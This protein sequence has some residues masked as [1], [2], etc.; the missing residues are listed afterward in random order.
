MEKEAPNWVGA[1]GRGEHRTV[2]SH[3]AWCYLCSEWCWSYKEGCCQ[4]CDDE[5]VPPRW[6]GENVGSVVADIRRQVEA[7]EDV[8]GRPTEAGDCL[9][10]AS[11]VLNLLDTGGSD[12]A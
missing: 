5:H 11:A 1:G 2:G 3:R 6:R 4:C 8:M 12:G 10:W 9:I 7:M